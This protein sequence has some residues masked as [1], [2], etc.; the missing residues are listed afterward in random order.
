MWWKYFDV[1]KNSVHWMLVLVKHLKKK[2]KKKKKKIQ[3]VDF[4]LDTS[5]AS[6][7]GNLLISKGAKA[8]TPG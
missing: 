6:L 3:N 7:S 8:K 2:Q 4:L 5:D 1:L